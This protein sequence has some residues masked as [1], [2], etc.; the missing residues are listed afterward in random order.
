VASGGSAAGEG[1]ALSCAQDRYGATC[2]HSPT[3][4][5]SHSTCLPGEAAEAWEA[6]KSA[7]GRFLLRDLAAGAREERA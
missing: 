6:D 7:I 3:V 4:L 2:S 1:V 5:V